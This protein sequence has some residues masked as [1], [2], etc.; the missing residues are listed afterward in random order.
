M[1]DG[2][3]GSNSPYPPFFGPFTPGGHSVI[4]VAGDTGGL[5][6]STTEFFGIGSHNDNGNNDESTGGWSLFG[7]GG[8]P[9]ISSG[10]ATIGYGGG[11]AG[12][13]DAN[14]GDGADGFWIIEYWT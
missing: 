12:H 10:D 5:P 2:Y 9:D 6:S 4:G 7:P 3:S 8:R 11:G 1:V 14:G 13:E